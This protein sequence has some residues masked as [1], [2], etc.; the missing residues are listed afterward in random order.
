MNG[1]NETAG[2][3]HGVA[4]NRT[5]RDGFASLAIIALAVAL[6]AFVVFN[7]VS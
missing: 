7:L 5:N 1:P 2:D 6:I 3:T 4:R